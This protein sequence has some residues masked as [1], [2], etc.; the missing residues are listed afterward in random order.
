MLITCLAKVEGVSKMRARVYL[1]CQ[2]FNKELKEERV[3]FRVEH[4]NSLTEGV[5]QERIEY[6]NVKKIKV[7]ILVTSK[8]N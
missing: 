8:K 1:F 7:L 5:F 4:S 2:V 6:V 3:G